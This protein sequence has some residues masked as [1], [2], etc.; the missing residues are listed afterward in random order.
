MIYPQ[1][2]L[3]MSTVRVKKS[4]QILVLIPLG[5]N[6]NGIEYKSL[7]S[8]T[9]TIETHYFY[10][11]DMFFKAYYSLIFSTNLGFPLRHVPVGAFALRTDYRITLIILSHMPIRLRTILFYYRYQH[12]P[13][14]YFGA[15]NE[16]D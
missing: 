7:M 8:T 3:V 12:A 11:L 15:L 10:E 1:L 16:Y 2:T 6:E 4:R 14:Q 9:S 5:P 13:M